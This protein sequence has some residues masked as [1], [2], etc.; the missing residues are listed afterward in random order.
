MGRRD[1]EGIGG[2][3]FSGS[4]GYE[5]PPSKPSGLFGL[6][7]AYREAVAAMKGTLDSLEDRVPLDAA[8][9]SPSMSAGVFTMVMNTFAVALADVG[10]GLYQ[11]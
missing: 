6:Q 2:R 8:V 5:G 4:T 10:C 11:R 7:E 9:S 1:E 3:L